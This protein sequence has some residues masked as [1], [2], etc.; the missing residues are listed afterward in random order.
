MKKKVT[1]VYRDFNEQIAEETIWVEHLGGNNYKV[2][3]V[4]FFAPNIALY[5]TIN[6]EDDGGILYF[7]ELVKTS[8][9]TTIQ[10][11]IKKKN[12]KNRII[13]ELENIGCHWEGMHDQMYLAVDISPE[14][15]YKVI[16]MYLNKEF[17][18]GI[19]DYK[20]ACLSKNHG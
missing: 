5:D 10:V 19:I 13:K 7:N 4:P 2:Q 14:L 17:K 15:D 16:K 8:E 11:V 18:K 3:N 9:H 12:E 1:L 6:V 20:E